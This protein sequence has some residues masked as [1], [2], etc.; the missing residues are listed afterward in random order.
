MGSRNEHYFSLDDLFSTHRQHGDDIVCCN[1]ESMSDSSPELIRSI[2]G[3][4]EQSI[5]HF[6]MLPHVHKTNLINDLCNSVS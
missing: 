4:Q 1:I 2:L 3:Y 6:R 5:K